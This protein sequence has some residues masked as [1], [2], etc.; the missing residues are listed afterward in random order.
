MF[1]LM[2]EGWEVHQKR[3]YRIEGR[4]GLNLRSRRARR[5]V[6]A[7]HR[8]QRPGVWRVDQWRGMD[9]VCDNLVDGHRIRVFSRVCRNLIDC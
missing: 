9:C 5:R 6:A 7:A 1:L 8:M 3:V 4:E 2:R